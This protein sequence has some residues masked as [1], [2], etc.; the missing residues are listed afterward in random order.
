[1]IQMMLTNTSVDQNRTLHTSTPVVNA[2]A[3]V[4]LG[5]ACLVG[6]PGNLI[7]IWTILCNIKQRS[8]TIVVILNLA[9]ADFVVLV[10]LPFWIYFLA[11]AWVFGIP[12]WKVTSCLIFSSMYASVFFITVMSVERLVGV[13]YPFTTQKWWKKVTVIKVVIGIWVSALLLAIPDVTLEI[14]LDANGRPRKRIYSSD[15]HE[16][17]ILLLQTMVGFLIPF[18]TLSVSYSCVSKRIKQMTFRTKNKSGMLIAR[19]VITF[20]ICWLPYHTG[21]IIKTSSLLAR[22]SNSELAK[23]LDKVYQTM[24]DAAGALAFISSC[25]NPILY[26]FAARSFKNGFKASNLA[27]VF[28]QMNSSFKEKRDKGMNDT[29]HRSE[30]INML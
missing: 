2:V 14:K 15:Q 7:V 5:L 28:E 6:V 29:E 10:T 13:L 24:N 11:D 12:F 1:M 4:V 16:V 21:N 30:S 26:A 19:V 20:V 25:I 22:N 23:K 17:G 18:I 3:C 27:S 9:V 8:P